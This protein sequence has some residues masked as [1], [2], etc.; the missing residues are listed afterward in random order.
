MVFQP[1]Y[2]SKTSI[3]CLA[4][5]VAAALFSYF[6]LDNQATEAGLLLYVIPVGVVVGFV[7]VW[8]AL[9]FSRKSLGLLGLTQMTYWPLF[10]FTLAVAGPGTI[11]QILLTTLV[12][13][14]LLAGIGIFVM[15]V[16]E[17][18]SAR[19]YSKVCWLPGK[20]P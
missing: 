5:C 6:L 3:L 19:G 18:R 7:T 20:T 16:F 17:R 15:S 10:A 14:C 13:I 1:M 9:L 8:Q 12:T 2:I 4:V 11:R